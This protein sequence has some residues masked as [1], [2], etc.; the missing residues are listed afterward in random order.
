MRKIAFVVQRY[1]TQVNGG[2]EYY[3]RMMAERLAGIYD[4]TVI[5]TT[6]VD[7][8]TWEKYYRK[9]R[10]TVNGVKVI[11]FDAERGRD[12]RLFTEMTQILSKKAGGIKRLQ[13]KNGSSGSAARGRS[14]RRWQNI[15]RKR[16][17]NMM[18]FCLLLIYFTQ[19]PYAF[20]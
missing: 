6:A 14:A 13:K 19:A 18:C 20:L 7:Y 5:T 10:E 15:L 1:G 4:V 11:R 9:K 3:V 2:A 8:M 17:T 16:N 12:M